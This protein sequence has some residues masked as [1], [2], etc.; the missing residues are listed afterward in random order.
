[1]RRILITGAS[2]YIGGRLLRALEARASRNEESETLQLRCMAR[3]PE[4]LRGRVAADT[5]IVAGDVADPASLR[6]ALTGVETAF[7]LIHS[8]AEAEA[9]VEQDRIGAA[10]FADAASAAGIKRIIYLGG[11]GSG[12]ELSRHLA[13]RQEV[14]R[15]LRDAGIPTIE[16]RASI[17]IGSGSLS[18]EL[19]RTLVSK[20]PIMIT[21]RWTQTLAQPIAIEDVIDYLVASI[22]LPVDTSRVFEIGGADQVSYGELMREYARQRGLKRWILP[23]PVLSP[24]LSSLWLGL[25]TPVYAGVGRKLIDSLR[26]ETI[27]HDQEARRVFGI[28][29]RGYAEAIR[30]ALINE[31]SEFAA[32]R[33]SDALSATPHARGY[34][35]VRFGNRLVYSQALQV[36][37]GPAQAAAPI[38]R[39]GGD[40][41][42]YFANWLW[43][44]RGILDLIVGGPGMRRGR[45]DP[46]TLSVGDTVDFWR[47]EAVE[48]S[49]LLRLAAEM[50]VP[51]RAWLQFEINATRQGSEIRQTAIFDPA[52]LFGL[53]YW[54]ASYPIHLVVFNSMLRRIATASAEGRD[55]RAGDG[56]GRSR[57]SEIVHK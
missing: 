28:S 54:Y 49:R 2:G 46:E 48:A 21:P 44:L 39:I 38:M 10:N 51:G 11:L 43:Q 40:R 56:S 24:R 25:V 47:V 19:I 1:M 37:C 6:S 42:W 32:T 45:R 36:T 34:G 13:S 7:Y 15:L 3:R 55:A 8:M 9:F 4:N 31:D 35:G 22:F 27:L 18:F 30:R 29:P 16:L 50:K 23:V 5:E 14:G 33:W 12:G 41:G 57:S 52:G 53:L 20:L 26:N 17:I